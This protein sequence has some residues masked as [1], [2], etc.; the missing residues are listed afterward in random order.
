MA[1]RNGKAA[2]VQLPAGELVAIRTQRERMEQELAVLIEQEK[3]LEMGTDYVKVVCDYCWGTGVNGD[4]W[5]DDWDEGPRPESEPC[6]ECKGNGYVFMRKWD[7]RKKE[8][9]HTH[10]VRLGRW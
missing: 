9:V 3:T 1:G 2:K 6:E 5:D 4:D 8:H 7:G 10:D